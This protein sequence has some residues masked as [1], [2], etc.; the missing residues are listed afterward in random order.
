MAVQIESGR[1][2]L[3]SWK[4]TYMTRRSDIEASGREYRWEFDKKRLFAKSDYMIGVCNDMEGVVNI[5]KEYKTMFGPEIKSMFS[6]QKHFDSLMENVLRL[7]EAFK[8]VT[9]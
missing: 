7:L 6:D 2:L 1:R 5:V 3:E 9:K 4:S 8:S